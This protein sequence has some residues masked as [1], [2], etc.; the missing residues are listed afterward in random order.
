MRA[1]LTLCA[2]AASLC[3][4]V[5]SASAEIPA[6]KH[7]FII[8]LENKN[9][10]STFGPSAGSPYLAQTL[11]SQGQL[12]TEYYGIGHPSLDNYIAMISGQPPNAETQTNCQ[13]FTEFVP[14]APPDANGVETGKGCVS[15][16]RTLTIADQLEAA[17]LTWKGYMEDMANVDPKTCRHPAI[18]AA[19]TTQGARANDQY[20]ARHNPFVYFHSII[21]RPICNTNVVDLS[22]LDTDLASASTTPTYSFITPDLCSD[23]HD[24]NC[25]DGGPGGY[26]GINNFLSTWVPK[27]TGSPAYADGGLLIVT[28]DEAS[29]DGSACCGEPTGPN[30]TSPGGGGRPGGGRTGAVLLSPF[31]RAGTQNATPYN[32]YSLLRSIEDMFGLTHLGYAAQDGLQVFGDDVFKAPPP[33]RDGDGKP[34]SEDACPDMPAATADGCPLPA[35]GD[36]DGDGKPDGE[37]ACPDVAAPTANGC[38]AGSIVDGPKPVVKISGV[39]RKCVRHAFEATVRVVSKRLVNVQSRVDGRRVKTSK[40]HRFSVNVEVKK[41]KKGKHRLKALARDQLG[42]TGSKTAKFRVC[43]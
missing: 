23:G 1:L 11:P 20:A 33:D 36:R 17:G 5:A 37:D 7:V 18:G 13:T 30:T 12:L 3:F 27:I 19:D 10:D 35:P 21:D 42:R 26:Q 31:I 14:T 41:L 22:V 25:A 16:A 9:Y 39:P 34:D 43:R 24:E 4:G 2:L 28:F 15:P 6:V 29:T 32:H 40:K 38:P 8:V